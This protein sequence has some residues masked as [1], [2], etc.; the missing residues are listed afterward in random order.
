MEN[1]TLHPQYLTDTAGKKLVVLPL[2][3]YK[4]LLEHLEEL[5]DILAYDEA[6]KSECEWVDA[7]K[8]FEEI[9]KKRKQ[10]V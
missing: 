5:E 2:D 3:E 6:K 7:E 1:L 4:A 10:Y 9:E 8:A